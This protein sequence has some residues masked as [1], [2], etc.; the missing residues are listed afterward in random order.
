MK[1]R[2]FLATILS[3]LIK[4]AVIIWIINF[5]Y[6]QTV[7]AF[8]FGYRVFTEEAVAPQ[9]GRDVPFSFTEGKSYK[10]IAQSLEEKGLV[11]DYKLAFVQ[12]LVS[13]RRE[14]LK[15][16][17]YTLNTSMTVEDMVNV[18]APDNEEAEDE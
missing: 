7:A 8:D 12:I 17:I 16:G 13:E 2:Q 1:V 15:P 6:T 5:I 4:I 11:R 3:A 14:F 10:D 18:M 9:P